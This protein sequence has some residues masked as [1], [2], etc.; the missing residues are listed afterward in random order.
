[1]SVSSVEIG[2]AGEGGGRR[3]KRELRRLV[4]ENRERE[5]EAGEVVRDLGDVFGSVY[6]R[7]LLFV[8]Y[9]ET[10]DAVEGRKREGREMGKESQEV[11]TGLKAVA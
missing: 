7:S 2:D 9:V 5:V 11:N 4:P 1:M 6:W 8:L 3:I 10:L